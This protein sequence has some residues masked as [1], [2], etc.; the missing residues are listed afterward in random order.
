[1]I[2]VS[3]ASKQA[4]SPLKQQYLDFYTSLKLHFQSKQYFNQHIGLLSLIQN[5]CE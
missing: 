5:S 1:M 4:D 2:S 3:N